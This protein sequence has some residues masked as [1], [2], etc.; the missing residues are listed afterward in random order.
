VRLRK[1]VSLEARKNRLFRRLAGALGDSAGAFAL[2]AA[3]A[4]LGSVFI[5]VCSFV[6]SSPYFAIKEIAVRGVREL[7]EKEVLSLAK[8][9]PHT[10]IM[11]INREVIAARVAANPWVKNIYIGREL[12]DRL[13]LD[14]RERRPVALVK[15]D[16]VFYLID[17]DGHVFKKLS[18]GDDVDLP[19]ITGMKINVAE[20]P[21]LYADTLKILEQLFTSG[22]YGFLGT[23]SEAHLDGV[24]GL[25]LLTDRGL[26]LKLGREDF[27][28]KLNQLK[29]VLAD[30]EKRGMGHGRLFVDLAD[31]SKVTVQ[32]M[33]IPGKTQERKKGPQYRI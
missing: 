14:I 10:N 29:I 4:L 7:T 9:R 2:L 25:S 16:G 5:F 20:K 28:G 21:L 24:F 17:C 31:I 6:L 8:V 33:E 18:Q 22:E 13:V 23:V 3:A 11:G 15:E 1:K 32:R 27:S 30:L 26:Y 19:V 12:P